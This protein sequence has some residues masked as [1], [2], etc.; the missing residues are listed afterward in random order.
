MPL[1]LESLRK[2]ADFQGR[3]RRSEYSS[4]VLLFLL[5]VATLGS[6]SEE[7]GST[8]DVYMVLAGGLYLGLLV[9][10]FAVQIRRLH[11]S[12]ISGWWSLIGIIP[13]VGFVVILV[14]L[15]R[16]GTPGDNRFGPDPKG[17]QAKAPTVAGDQTLTA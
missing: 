12:D 14:L 2:Y 6:L 8:Y 9:S 11:Y 10:M 17:R 16:D 1:V 3:A 5:F 7:R 15:V 13:I 4:F